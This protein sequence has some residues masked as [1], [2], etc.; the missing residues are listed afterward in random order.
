MRKLRLEHSWHN[1]NNSK[2]HEAFATSS[3]LWAG[4]ENRFIVEHYWKA[5]TFNRL[6]SKIKVDESTT[7]MHGFMRAG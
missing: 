1:P 6:F 3:W 2:L 5:F 4:F 7:F